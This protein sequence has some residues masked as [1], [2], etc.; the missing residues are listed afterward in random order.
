M[1][2]KK[3]WHDTFEEARSAGDAMADKA[4]YVP[5]LDGRPY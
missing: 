5:I 4:T 3:T 1:A 2:D